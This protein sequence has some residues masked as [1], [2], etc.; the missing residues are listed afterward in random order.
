[1]PT[2]TCRMSTLLVGWLL[3]AGVLAQQPA[4]TAEKPL[5]WAKEMK[6]FADQDAR[7]PPEPGGIVFV[8]SS[9]IVRWDLGKWFEGLEPKPVN[10]GF[11][12]SQVSDTLKNLERLVLVRQPR[13]VVFYAGDNDV[14]AGKKVDRIVE[15]YRKLLDEIHDK[16]PQTRVVIVGIKPSR[17]RW[18]M[19]DTMQGVNRQVHELCK[20]RDHCE[21]VDVWE[22]MLG[23]DGEPR[24]SLFV[25]DGLH[26]SDEGYKLWTE[27]VT[28]AVKRQLEA[29]KA[30]TT[31]EAE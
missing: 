28:P 9:S 20:E 10:R 6:R 24:E 13:L 27:K 23:D 25:K 29:T 15:D 1:M 18:K 31:G 3:A 5:P 7:Q 14:A 22:P 30:A 21:F 11:G 16:V 2:T 12:G 4:E 8:G 26:L 19:A 17:A